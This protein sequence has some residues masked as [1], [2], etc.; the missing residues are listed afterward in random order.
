M[1]K[2]NVEIW[3]DQMPNKIKLGT[4]EIMAEDEAIALQQAIKNTEH[5]VVVAK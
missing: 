1:Q 3:F 2:Y 5:W 4:V